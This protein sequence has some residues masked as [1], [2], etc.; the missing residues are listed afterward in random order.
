MSQAYKNHNTNLLIGGYY[1]FNPK[2]LFGLSLGPSFGR[3]KANDLFSFDNEENIFSVFTQYQYPKGYVNGIFSI[4]DTK[5]NNIKRKIPL[6]PAVDVARG[7]TDGLHYGAT[8]T[9]SYFIYRTRYFQTGPLINI[10]Y[11]WVK[12]DGYEEQDS[13][14]AGTLLRFYDQRFDSLL[15]TA[16]W[17]GT[18]RIVLPISQL[19]FSGDLDYNYQALDNSGFE[20]EA[21]WW[22]GANWLRILL[23]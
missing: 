19:V 11:Q 16:G 6:G 1:F 12:V 20:V 8:V 2:Y 17:Q 4:G 21:A 15:L 13:D 18:Y 3:T 10:E 14:A 7:D 22:M 9:G 23:T 5:Y